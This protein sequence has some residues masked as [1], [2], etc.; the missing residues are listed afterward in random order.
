ME[1]D[2]AAKM[3][4]I[5]LSE[6]LN[7]RKRKI[8]YNPGLESELRT[9]KRKESKALHEENKLKHIAGDNNNVSDKSKKVSFRNSQILKQEA[10]K[11]MLES[12]KKRQNFK[13]KPTTTTSLT[14]VVSTFNQLNFKQYVVFTSSFF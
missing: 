7:P 9:R 3:T 1:Q 6:T 11:K 8:E 5:Y 2:N 13:E 4:P 10:T 12:M 14:K